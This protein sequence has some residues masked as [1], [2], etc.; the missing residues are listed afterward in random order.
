MAG[1]WCVLSY[2]RKNGHCTIQDP[3]MV[4][5]Y[6]IPYHGLA[7]DRLFYCSVLDEYQTLYSEC[8]EEPAEVSLVI[9]LLGY[10]DRS[11]IT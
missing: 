6:F 5:L 7:A 10:S 8:K 11:L 3:H 9:G 2:R 1:V 4:Y